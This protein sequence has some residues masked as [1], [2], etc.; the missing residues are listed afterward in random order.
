MQWQSYVA[1]LASH[2]QIQKTYRYFNDDYK[3][4]IKTGW[5]AIW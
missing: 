5:N 4:D 3:N 1:E 2:N